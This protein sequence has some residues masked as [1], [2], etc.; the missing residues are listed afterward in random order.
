ML[1]VWHHFWMLLEIQAQSSFVTPARC[2]PLTVLT[3]GGQ[4]WGGDQ[5]P[6]RQAEGG[7]VSE[8]VYLVV[9]WSEQVTTVA[10]WFESSTTSV[11][12]MQAETRAEFA[13]RSVA[14]LEKT[15]DDLEGRF[16]FF[17]V[18]CCFQMLCQWWFMGKCFSKTTW[19]HC[20]L[21]SWTIAWFP[22]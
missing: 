3:E 2:F 14:K 21:S 6:H 17:V 8:G 12:L 16:F 22:S 5:G 11:S 19:A 10:S 4:V 7:T 1:Y 15:I 18:D 13:E 20:L 9:G